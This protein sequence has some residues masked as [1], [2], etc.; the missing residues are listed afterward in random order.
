MQQY[1]YG[2][3]LCTCKNLQKTHNGSTHRGDDML[4]YIQRQLRF[5]IPVSRLPPDSPCQTL[6]IET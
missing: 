5:K 3:I 6:S 2:I 1:K 4:S